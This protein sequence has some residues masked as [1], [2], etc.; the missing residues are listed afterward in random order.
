MIIVEIIE[1]NFLFIYSYNILKL[2]FFIFIKFPL[3]KKNMF[4]NNIYNTNS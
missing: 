1:I 4:K 2:L 3:I